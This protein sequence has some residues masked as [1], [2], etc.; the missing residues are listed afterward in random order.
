ME[1]IFALMIFFG[2]FTFLSFGLCVANS[3]EAKE[4]KTVGNIMTFIA[5]TGMVSFLIGC[6]GLIICK[7]I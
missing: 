6:V 1:Q 4:S 3:I 5:I 7:T 2:G